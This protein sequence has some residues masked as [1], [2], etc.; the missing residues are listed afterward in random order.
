MP[1]HLFLEKEDEAILKQQKPTLFCSKKGGE[2]LYPM[3]LVYLQPW[4]QGGSNQS[5]YLLTGPWKKA[6]VTPGKPGEAWCS[7]SSPWLQPGWSKAVWELVW[8]L[9][10][11][12]GGVPTAAEHAALPASYSAFLSVGFFI[13]KPGAMKMMPA[14]HKCENSRL[15][16]SSL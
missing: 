7:A 4:I 5:E 12:A 8:A 11:G 13:C 10:G 16:T 6:W 15:A 14:S 1:K 2:V 3:E 9:G